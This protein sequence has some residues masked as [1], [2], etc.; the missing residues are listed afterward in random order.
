MEELEH[1]PSHNSKQKCLSAYLDSG[2]GN[3]KE[4]VQVICRDPFNKI[5]IGKQ[6][7]KKYYVPITECDGKN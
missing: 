7:A 5:F 1:N 6:I 2:D 4:V 3:W